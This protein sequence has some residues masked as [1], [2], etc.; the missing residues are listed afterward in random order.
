MIECD[1]EVSYPLVWSLAP[2]QVCIEHQVPLTGA[3][4]LCHRVQPFI[5][6]F[7]DLAA[8]DHCGGSLVTTKAYG[9]ITANPSK[10]WVAKAVGGMVSRNS[11]PGFNPT[12]GFFRAF[13]THQ[14]AGAADGNRA[15]YCRHLGI[16]IHG[17]NG[18]LNKDQHP[19]IGQLLTFCHGADVMP[20][21]VFGSPLRSHA[22]RLPGGS[23]LR[24]TKRRPSPRLSG[25]GR[26][27]VRQQLQEQ[28]DTK[29]GRSLSEVAREAGVTPGYVRYW[30]P[31]L[32]SQ[33]CGQHRV[34]RNR[35]SSDY[36][37]KQ[38]DEVFRVVA[39]LK[40]SGI[41]PSRRQVDRRLRGKCMS[42]A[43]PYL[44]AAYAEAIAA[45]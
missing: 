2:Y 11:A 7:P 19:S 42:L 18:W 23:A 25:Q 13:V 14:V 33:L 32:A 38:R 36:H 39:A 8:C 27:S 22:A 29:A 1:D 21:E 3:C 26:A 9:A 40:A 24:I 35:R 15:K 34:V 12:V 45:S 16:N 20:S 37:A 31:E 10:V 30:F 43:L 28:L 4:P 44:Q 17:L 41:Y 5:P 6:K